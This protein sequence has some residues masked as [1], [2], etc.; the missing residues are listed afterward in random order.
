MKTIKTY[1]T[2]VEADLARIGPVRQA[3]SST[4]APLADA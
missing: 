4:C 2:G 3:C 1:S